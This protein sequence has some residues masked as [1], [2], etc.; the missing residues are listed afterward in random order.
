M[1]FQAT[2]II[3]DMRSG[4][5]LGT[6]DATLPMKVS[7]QVNGDYPVMTAMSITIYANDTLSTQKY[8][9]GKVT[10][11]TPFYGADALGNLQYYSY[12]I[13]AAQLS[14][15]GIT[16]GNE[17]KMVIT[18][19]YAEGSGEGSVTQSSASVFITR[20][21]P[22]FFLSP[23]PATVANNMHTFTM[24]Y[25]QEQGDTLDWIRY[26]IAQGSDTEDPIF[27]SG[28]I[29]GAAVYTCTYEQ[30][31]TGFIYSFRATAQTS[32]GVLLDT[33]WKTFYVG[34][35]VTT[36]E[37]AVIV[38]VRKDINGVIVDWSGV[39]AAGRARWNVFRE[40]GDDGVLVKVA[41]TEVS[42]RRII[43]YGAPSGQGPYRYF[44]AGLNSGGSMV[45]DRYGS[46]QIRPIF[47]RWTLLV[48]DGNDDGSFTVEK[49]Y[50]FKYN[51]DSGNVGNNNAPNV[52]Q[53]FT[54]NPTVQPAPQNYLSGT[55]KALIGS[56]A[57]GEYTDSLEDRK[58]LMALS[59]S[60]KPMFLKSSKG[61]VLRIR[62][63]GAV[64][65]AITEK[66]ASLAQSVSFPWIALEDAEEEGIFAVDIIG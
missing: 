36:D 14:S 34:Y 48:C 66:T 45:G 2:N 1:L 26:Q 23:L 15:A 50:H 21:T 57:A 56:V 29:Y 43:D 65:A 11:S 9:T 22:T 4:V 37:D 27:D 51:M 64:T 35:P 17:Y 38:S 42:V 5:G 46:A 20:K 55:L 60:E 52:L 7:W 41:D 47:Y 33:G 59:V 39:T 40:R 63:N 61:D 6:I 3:P 13:T 58:A 24:N 28:N 49:Q 12:T 30:F 44:V 18:Q 8:T 25:S 31:R 62:P 19:Y 54:A 53:N 10:F 32:S 16:N